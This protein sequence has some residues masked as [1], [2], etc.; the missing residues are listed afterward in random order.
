MLSG[1]PVRIEKSYAGRVNSV[2]TEIVGP[3][4]TV[5][6]FEGIHV[7]NT[8]NEKLPFIIRLFVRAGDSSLHFMHTFIY[9]GDENKDFLKGLGIT[10]ERS[11]IGEVYNRHVKF[12][13]DHGTFHEVLV[14]LTSWH[15]PVSR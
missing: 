3:L 6:R 5:F 13:G 10:F 12:T 7:S 11:M 14:G 4:E 15:P 9:D 1:S 2:T 8:G